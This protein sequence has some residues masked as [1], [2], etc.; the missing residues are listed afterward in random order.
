MSDDHYCDPA[1]AVRIRVHGDNSGWFIDAVDAEG[2]Y[3]EACWDSYKVAGE[4]YTMD[5]IS[6]ALS[7]CEAF[8][9]EVCPHLLGTR[10]FVPY[11]CILGSMA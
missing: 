2:K 4:W 3:T 7:R 6:I 10:P 5:D 8:A 11:D 9:R 1:D